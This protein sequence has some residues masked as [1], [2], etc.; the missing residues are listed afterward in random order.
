MSVS[1]QKRKH[2][3]NV[4]LHHIRQHID[5]RARFVKGGAIRYRVWNGKDY[6]KKHG[7]PMKRLVVQHCDAAEQRR[8]F[9]EVYPS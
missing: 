2:I 9:N 6:T 1:N 5:K 8:I 4:L 3:G 7:K